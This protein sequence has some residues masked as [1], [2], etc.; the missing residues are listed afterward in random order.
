MLLNTN[1]ILQLCI[2]VARVQRINF[3]V[4]FSEEDESKKQ[5]V[6]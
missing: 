5:F 2:Q 1:P 3:Y 4:L 6:V